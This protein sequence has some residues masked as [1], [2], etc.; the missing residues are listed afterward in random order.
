VLKSGAEGSLHMDQ[1]LEYNQ[2][3]S[4]IAELLT[5]RLTVEALKRVETSGI[6]RRA[7]ASRLNT[8]APQLYR[9]LDPTNSKKSLAQLI[10]LLHLLDCEVQLV[11]KSRP[12]A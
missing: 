11:V 12:A 1:V 10:S 5:H 7:L 9:L 4:Y 2:D 8:S 3:P 6:S